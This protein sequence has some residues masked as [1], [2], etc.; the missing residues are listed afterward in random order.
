M[1]EGMVSMTRQENPTILPVREILIPRK[2][3]NPTKT[4]RMFLA[5]GPNLSPGR[6]NYLEEHVQV[7]VTKYC[8][9][10]EYMT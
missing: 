5:Y 1:D 4:Y 2:N 3:K 9:T 6:Y 8:F 7:T 10:L